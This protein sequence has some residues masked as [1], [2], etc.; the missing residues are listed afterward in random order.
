MVTFFVSQCIL[1]SGVFRICE[2]ESRVPLR[3]LAYV[4]SVRHGLKPDWN[5]GDG[6]ADH[7]GMVVGEEWS[8]GRG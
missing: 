5:S 7:E 3:P 2:R 1:R 4:V 6:E 8:V